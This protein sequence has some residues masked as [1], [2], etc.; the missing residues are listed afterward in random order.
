MNEKLTTEAADCIS[1]YREE[2]LIYLVQRF[3]SLGFAQRVLAETKLR[4]DD[5][6]FLNYVP[7]PHIYLIGYALSLG[8]EFMQA[9]Q[10]GREREVKTKSVNSGFTHAYIFHQP[11]SNQHI[12]EHGRKVYI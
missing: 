9:E 7:N 3:G 5:S 11:I 2:L 10:K 8:L 1:C 6:D 12:Q 4:L